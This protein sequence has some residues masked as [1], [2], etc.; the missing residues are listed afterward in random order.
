MIDAISRGPAARDQRANIL[1]ALKSQYSEQQ[2]EFNSFNIG[3]LP[4]NGNFVNL[5]HID[6][7]AIPYRFQISI[8]M[9]Y[10][11]KLIQSVDYYDIFN[12]PTVITNP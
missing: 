3:S 5:S 7:A 9:Q 6:G 8:N 11:V 1:M 10:F 4:A 2:Q 12:Q